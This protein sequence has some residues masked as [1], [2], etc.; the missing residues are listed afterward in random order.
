MYLSRGNA[1]KRRFGL[2]FAS[3]AIA[4]LMWVVLVSM[5]LLQGQHEPPLTLHSTGNPGAMGT[6]SMIRGAPLPRED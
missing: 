1:L 3:D 4:L 5:L 2:A 6:D